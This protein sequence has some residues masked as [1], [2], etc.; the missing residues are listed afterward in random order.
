MRR[1]TNRLWLGAWGLALACLPALKIPNAAAA[2]FEAGPATGEK[3]RE[4]RGGLNL[5]LAYPEFGIPAVDE[6][7]TAWTVAWAEKTL[8]RIGDD[9]DLAEEEWGWDV[10]LD[11]RLTRP[12]PQAASVIFD[13]FLYSRGAAH[14]INLTET[15]NLS[16]PAGERLDWDRLFAKPDEALSIFAKL[17]PGLVEEEIRQRMPDFKLDPDAWLEGF[18]PSREN[19]AALALEPGGVRV[20]FQNYQ[21]GPYVIGRPE[22]LIPLSALLPAGPNPG[23]WPAAASSAP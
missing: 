20:C 6:A 14:P 15:L 18:D 22:V 21:I 8:S 17:S 9:F 13:I 19:Y 2:A 7:I 3:R 23:I 10:S 5:T 12:S 16:L 1:K 11:Y 4:T